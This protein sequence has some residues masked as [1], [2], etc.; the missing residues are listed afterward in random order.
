MC[1]S[2][3]SFHHG[4]NMLIGNHFLQ[5]DSKYVELHAENKVRDD[6][7]RPHMLKEI[8]LTSVLKKH[9]TLTWMMLRTF[10]E[11]KLCCR[12][13]FSSSLSSSWS[14]STSGWISSSTSFCWVST[15]PTVSLFLLKPFFRPSAR[16]PH[17]SLSEKEQ[18][19]WFFNTFQTVSHGWL[20]LFYLLQ[21]FL[22]RDSRIPG[23]LWV[24]ERLI[25]N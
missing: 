6:Y 24:D 20:I 19:S 11:V 7:A 21:G 23:G 2:Y 14:I 4:H 22:Y 17:C 9:S 15:S 8:S 5:M 18:H 13:L 3:S 25:I 16:V 12:D 1:V 10:A